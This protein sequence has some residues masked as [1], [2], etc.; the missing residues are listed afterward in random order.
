M[1][2]K[3]YSFVKIEGKGNSQYTFTIMKSFETLEAAQDYAKLKG[4]KL[5]DTN[6]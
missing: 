1:A 3:L 4:Y 5:I 6:E 2:K